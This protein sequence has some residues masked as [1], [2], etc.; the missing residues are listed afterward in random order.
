M[1]PRHLGIEKPRFVRANEGQ[2]I[3]LMEAKSM[4][5]LTANQ[6][7]TIYN[8]FSFGLISML[9]CTVYTLVSQSRVLP[10]YRNAL[11]LSSMVTF[12]AGYHYWRIFNSFSESSDGY[13]VATT[14]AGSFNE[15][16]R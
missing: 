2:H 4:L 16:Y 8:V 7:N 15:G 9:A 1:A 13:M 11:V 3:A 5:E 14:G 12:I 6:W 10:K